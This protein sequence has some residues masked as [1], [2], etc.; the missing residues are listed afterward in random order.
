MRQNNII[1]ETNTSSNRGRLSN[2][3]S[4]DIRIIPISGTEEIGKN[5]TAIEYNNEIL[6]IDAGVQHNTAQM[7][8]VDYL[9]PN[10]KYIEENKERIKGIILT[11]SR[12][13]HIGSLLYFLDKLNS[14]KIYA[15]H[16][17]NIML[18]KIF[19]RNRVSL[20]SELIN[21][22]KE[23]TVKIS[24]FSVQFWSINTPF[25]D[26]LNITIH[27]EH[28]AVSIISDNS[29]TTA[30]EIT[31]NKENNLLLMAYSANSELPEFTPTPSIIKSK[32]SAVFD[33][34]SKNRLFIS[35]FASSPYHILC[36]LEECKNR[37]K[38]II[39]E[40]LPV[41]MVL[42][43]LAETGH[44]TNYKD[45][46]ISE[47][48]VN[49][50][51]DEDLVIFITGPEGDEFN[52]LKRLVNGAHKFLFIKNKDVVF[53]TAHTLTYNQRAIQNLKNSLSR[54]G[55]KV[56]H[57][58]NND[59]GI[60]NYGNSEN[61]KLLHNT[62]NPRFFIPIGGT[63]YMLK[64]HS[65][66]ERKMGTPENHIMIPENG[67]CIEINNDGSRISNTRDKIDTESWVVDGIKIGKVQNIVIRDRSILS[68][69]GIFLVIILIDMRSNMLK[70]M[71]DIVSRGFVYLKESQ[72]LLYEAKIITKN[73]IEDY[74]SRGNEFD[75]DEVKSDLQHSL[76]KFLLQ[77]TAKEPVIMPIFIRV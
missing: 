71:P 10:T 16:Y 56:I 12:L 5:M 14:P 20:N 25:L 63:P 4:G 75:I 53:F 34:Y 15:R 57:Y 66:I 64:V 6:L 38:K 23:E 1:R 28:G 7:P 42:E 36:I 19:N 73:K 59:F 74:L 76:S 31:I 54:S 41:R 8:G 72:D 18:D 58:K 30:N 3:K 17:T 24:N 45:C 43:V 49:K 2:L 62:L 67:L 48:D 68:E 26:S 65:D 77:K 50:Y 37:N 47:I 27:T 61:L 52:Y 51:R 32:I 21:I 33:K 70:K 11:N 22:E 60:E 40:S 55:A 46:Y 13:E 9:I 44:N 29:Q 39:V 35:S 69:Q